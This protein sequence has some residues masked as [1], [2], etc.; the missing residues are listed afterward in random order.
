MLSAREG[1][2]EAL[3]QLGRAPAELRVDHSSAATHRVGTGPEREFNEEFVALCQYYGM[4]PKTIGVRCP[5]ENGDVESSNGHLKRRL[6]Q[7]LL[8]RGSREFESQAQYVG[9]LHHVLAKANRGRGEELA[10]ELAVMKPLPPTRLAEY[11]ELVCRVSSASTI[12][13]KKVAYSVPARWIGAE[14]KVEVYES[15]LK[16]YTGREWLLTLSRRRGTAVAL[17]YRHVVDHLLRKPGALERY[18][19]REQ[20]FP[21]QVF[22]QAHDRLVE[23]L[24]PR[25]GAVEYLRLLKLASEVGEREVELMLVEYTCPP[26]PQWSVEQI[27]QALAPRPAQRVAMDELTPECAGYDRLLTREVACA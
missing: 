6:A 14:L 11:D 16:L 17:D 10:K 15:Q 27:R 19:Y 9:F 24:G 12:R 7:H 4:T 20:M 21:G 2:Q 25:R 26:Y 8:L 1:L 5:N 18:R 13:V 22:R 23:E 3:H